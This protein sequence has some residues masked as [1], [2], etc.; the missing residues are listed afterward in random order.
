MP[1]R[2]PRRPRAET[3]DEIL[4]IAVDLMARD[5]VAA[6]SLSDVARRLGIQ[7]PSLYKYFPSKLALYDALFTEGARRALA[8]FRAGAETAEPGLPALAAGI[9]RL[10]RFVL[11]NP[12]YAQLLFWR[13]VPGF[14]PSAEAYLPAVQMVD[15]IGAVVRAAVDHGQLHPDAATEDGN[16]VLS[17]LV[18]GV[19]T[20]QLANEPA[21][22]FDDG[23]FTRLLPRL[24]QMYAASYPPSQ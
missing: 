11:D 16:A 3:I 2:R 24:L 21:A 20:Q 1:G 14:Q 17:S 23:R 12:T 13:P 8:E 5:G 7:P 6:L 18:A 15:E 19:F 9:E 22:S 10:G 4:A